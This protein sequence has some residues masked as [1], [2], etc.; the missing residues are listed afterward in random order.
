MF[1]RKEVTRSGLETGGY[2]KF[3][4]PK[5]MLGRS[6]TPWHGFLYITYFGAVNCTKYNCDVV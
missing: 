6:P 2:V 5:R 1:K 4:C 3:T